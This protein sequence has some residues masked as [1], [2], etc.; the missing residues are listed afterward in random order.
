LGWTSQCAYSADSTEH[1]SDG[2]LRDAIDRFD[3]ASVPAANLVIE[4]YSDGQ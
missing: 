2:E 4:L 3:P 1:G